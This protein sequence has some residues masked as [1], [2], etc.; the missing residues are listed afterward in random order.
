MIATTAALDPAAGAVLAKA[1]TRAAAQLELSS[2]ALGKI[3]GVSEA[4]VSRIRSG[5][6]AIEP[7]SKEGELASL[8][9]RLYL[10][11]DAMVGND[12][13]RRMDWFT[14]CNH[15][16]NGAPKDLVLTA[17]GLVRMVMYL[18]R[19]RATI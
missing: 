4:T 2:A 16:F 17:Q 14:A 18:D 5:A 13:K 9:V 10:S 11:L 1:T 19:M 6:R 15:A 12:E 8:L 3:L 7:Q